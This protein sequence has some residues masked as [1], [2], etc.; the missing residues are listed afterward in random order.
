MLPTE[1]AAMTGPHITVNMSLLQE[2]I[3]SL[4]SSVSMNVAYLAL[5][6]NVCHVFAK[7][8]NNYHHL[9]SLPVIASLGFSS[10]N[11]I[12]LFFTP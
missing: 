7:M 5:R 1:M 3:I 12:S 9:C 8:V 2:A 4:H 11:L 6:S 10:G